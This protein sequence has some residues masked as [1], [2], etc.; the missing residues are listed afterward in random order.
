N[1]IG[2]E[3][4]NDDAPL[5]VGRA[6][7]SGRWA[8]S[9]VEF[10]DAAQESGQP[11]AVVNLS[12]D[13]TQIDADGNITTRYEFTPMERAA[14][15]YARQNN[16]MLVVAA[17]N[18][19]DVMSVL[20]QASQEFDNILTVGAAEQFDLET[21]VWKGS[22]RT[23]YSSYGHGLDVM[24]YGGTADNPQLSLAE[25]G[26]SGMAGTS[27]ATAK[28]TGAVSQVWAANPELSYRQV[29]EIIKN[30]AT[31]LGS[32]SHDAE[33]GAGLLNIAAAV[34][35]AKATSGEEHDVSSTLIP[36]TWSGEGVFTAGDRAVNS[37]APTLTVH[38]LH[39]SPNEVISAANFFSV[40]HQDGNPILQYKFYSSDR[41]PGSGYFTL[42]GVKTGVSFTINADQLKDLQFVSGSEPGKTQT[43]SIRASDGKVWSSA[44][45][46]VVNPQ[47]INGSIQ[48]NKQPEI[49][50]YNRAFKP[51][52]TV[53]LSTLFSVNDA[54]GDAMQI[55]HIY[56]R[57]HG[58]NSGYITLNGVKQS[59]SIYVNASQLKDMQFVASSEAGK[60]ETLAIRAFDGK[61]WS[62]YSN[63]VANPLP[64][65]GS[66]AT[67]RLPVISINNVTLS[68]GATVAGSSLFS[69]QDSDG[70][71]IQ[72]YYF[73]NRDSS[74]D[75][76]YFT[77]N[78]VKQPRTLYINASQLKDLQFVAGS[79][80]G[81]EQS[82]VI[83]AFDGK[84][85]SD[86][87]VVPINSS[88]SAQSPTDSLSSV[89]KK[90]I[91]DV[92]QVNK[93]KLG[94]PISEPVDLGNGFLKQ[95][96]ES[97]YI[98]WNGQ[99]AIPYLIGTG[100][101]SPSINFPSTVK[102]LWDAVAPNNNGKNKLIFYDQD[103]G[104]HEFYRVNDNGSMHLIRKDSG[105]RKT[106]DMIIPGDFNGDGKT[107]LLFYDRHTGDYEFYRVN[108]NGSMHLIRKD[109]GW[110]K[111]WDMI[112]PGDFNGDGKTNLLFY[113]RHTGDY[114]FYRVNDNGSMNRIRQGSGWRKTW[115]M[116]IPDAAKVKRNT[117]GGSYY[118]NIKDSINQ[119]FSN[120]SGW[121][122]K[123]LTEKWDRV[124]GASGQYGKY[125]YFV[126]GNEW[127]DEMPSDVLKIY[128]DLSKTVVGNANRVTA[129]YAYDRGYHDAYGAHSGIDISTVPG[130]S[131]R[132]ATKGRV[133]SVENR[134]AVNGNGWWIA[135]D[136]LN[137]NNDRTGRRWWYGHLNGSDV[138]VGQQVSAAE[139]IGATGDGTPPRHHL[140][141]VAIDTY[142]PVSN[143]NEII[144][145][146]GGTYT[147]NVSNVLSRTMSPLQ[148]Y[149]NS[150]N[151]IKE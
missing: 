45:N 113:D 142:A 89:A 96:F 25:E 38:N 30:T 88:G 26:T 130:N 54:D 78:G 118:S 116:I 121:S 126:S 82:I 67:N 57:N 12:M 21:S 128:E 145:G 66:A 76:S 56:D 138:E 1:D 120:I 43:F 3:G 146:K 36:E 83:S 42:N 150:R 80:P 99:K 114:E 20:G 86:D 10:V 136:E 60:T 75:G 84:H 13:L 81:K 28:V 59:G 6:V 18:D 133:V 55:Y 22:D 68:P 123:S 58:D 135:I 49:I 109:S 50:V 73:H 107:N 125:S 8:E 110:R 37:S 134:M 151:G 16:V 140:H 95:G 17:G 70:D 131:I 62:Q 52:E 39:A 7:G 15:E 79:E 127:Q 9:L 97:G 108:D 111:T 69:V 47:T 61:H 11:N 91:D 46:A 19:G 5:W 2:I 119:Y 117:G 77:L 24:A 4:I 141:L 64:I 144:N 72:S 35:L 33:T 48:E 65:N 112:I 90:A 103:S 40:T 32:T 139:N 147:Q 74:S 104:D 29:V 143:W 106:W 149:W 51:E 122:N 137:D 102:P 53:P 31:D 101:A 27:V 100:K 129:G 115:D 14:I 23:D 105:W 98:T 87:L 124:G 34:H 92:Y 94:Q 148:A 63:F 44:I 93:N 85:W 71:D 41:M 132:S